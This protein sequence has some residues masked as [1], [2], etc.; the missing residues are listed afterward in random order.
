M[1]KSSTGVMLDRF[2]YTP[3]DGH[4]YRWQVGRDVI[5]IERIG[6]TVSAAHPGLPG[7]VPIGQE[8]R[9]TFTPTGDTIPAPATATATAMAAAVDEW[10][11]GR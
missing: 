9:L 5:T 4:R 6:R 2:T 11:S 8:S 7:G 10:R 1:P 3:G